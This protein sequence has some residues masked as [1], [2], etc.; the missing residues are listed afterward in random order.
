MRKNIGNNNPNHNKNT[1]LYISY[2]FL[3]HKS[4]QFFYIIRFFIAFILAVSMT[5]TVMLTT[6]YLHFIT[7]KHC[8]CTTIQVHFLY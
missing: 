8:K 5:S 1:D 4:N 7:L 6:S 2:S 3:V